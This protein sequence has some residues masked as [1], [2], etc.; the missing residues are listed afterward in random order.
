[1]YA[2]SRF[3][4]V[5]IHS[6]IKSKYKFIILIVCRKLHVHALHVCAASS[7]THKYD[8]WVSKLIFR[9]NLQHF[10]ILSY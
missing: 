9:Y 1:M 4:N 2:S 3:M 8:V 7:N 6:R 5:H 10:S